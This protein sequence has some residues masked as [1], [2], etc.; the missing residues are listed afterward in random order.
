MTV[1][2]DDMYTVPMG[3][4]NPKHRRGVTYKM[5][6]MIAD[7]EAELHIMASKLGL[8]REWYQGDHYDVTK[9][10]RLEAIV[11][12]GAVAVTLRQL[13]AMSALRRRDPNAKLA[14]PKQAEDLWAA[15][16]ENRR[17]AP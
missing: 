14:D 2:V 13:A 3:E 16:R 9:S 8:K 6:H 4:F 12:H 5:S 15:E 1:Y 17:A 11:K 7:T 10:K